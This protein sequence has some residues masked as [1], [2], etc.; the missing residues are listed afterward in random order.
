[1]ANVADLVMTLTSIWVELLFVLWL[2]AEFLWR[3]S[4]RRPRTKA[5]RAF[6]ISTLHR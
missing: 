6:F 3:L 5:L 2:C 1:V 4:P